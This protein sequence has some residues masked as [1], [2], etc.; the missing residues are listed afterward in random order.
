MTSWEKK[1]S[2]LIRPALCC[3]PQRM[4]DDWQAGG[5]LAFN[6]SLLQPSRGW[7]ISLSFNRPVDIH[8]VYFG[9]ADPPRKIPFAV[10]LTQ[11]YVVTCELTLRLFR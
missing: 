1:I 9:L 11:V 7:T 8:N 4:T 10:C 5:P 6:P 2:A 3:R